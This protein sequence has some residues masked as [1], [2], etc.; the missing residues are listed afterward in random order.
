MYTRHLEIPVFET[1]HVWVEAVLFNQA[2]RVSK[3]F[4]DGLRFAIP[5]LKTLELIV[6]RDAWI[7]VD[8]ALN[9]V[10]VAAWLEFETRHRDNLHLP[11]NC[12]LRLFHVH[13]GL[14]LK[15]AQQGMLENLSAIL[16]ST[17]K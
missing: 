11:V 13:A 15:R 10:P 6:Q 1:R 5:E 16:K 4:P 7:I 2:Q 9:D 14:V 12:H 8:K 3:R 17:S